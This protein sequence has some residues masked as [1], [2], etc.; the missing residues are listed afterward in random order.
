MSTLRE[1]ILLRKVLTLLVARVLGRVLDLLLR[2]C[3]ILC[4]LLRLIVLFGVYVVI[5]WALMCL[6]R[7]GWL[8]PHRILHAVCM[9]LRRCGLAV[10]VF[11]KPSI[12]T[13]VSALIRHS[14]FRKLS[15]VRHIRFGSQQQEGAYM[16]RLK[17]RLPGASA[18]C[19]DSATDR[20]IQS[21]HRRSRGGES[22]TLAGKV[23]H[24]NN[25]A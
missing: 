22:Q 10:T 18:S 5:Y 21:H 3:R 19:G 12:M 23:E 4:L 11:W 24:R 25:E 8:L 9:I 2:G 15:R 1:L 13:L 7:Y 6:L 14:L 20:Q 17:S 16:A